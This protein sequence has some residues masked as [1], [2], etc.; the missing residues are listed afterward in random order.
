MCKLAIL[1]LSILYIARVPF[2][3]YTPIYIETIYAICWIYHML[4]EYDLSITCFCTTLRAQRHGTSR[5]RS[6][7][8]P[9]SNRR[10]GVAMGYDSLEHWTENPQNDIQSIDWMY[11]IIRL[12][13]KLRVK[14]YIASWLTLDSQNHSVARVTDYSENCIY[15]IP[16]RS[17]CPLCS[18]S[19]ANH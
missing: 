18:Y 1:F 9:T 4:I 15:I 12:L 7:G 5:R 16:R 10:L 14:L 8:K 13:G 11:V 6:Q 2:N 17:C 19:S 3:L